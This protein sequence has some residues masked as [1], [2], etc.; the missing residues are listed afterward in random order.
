[1]RARVRAC[2]RVRVSCRVNPHPHPNPNPNPNP[3]PTRTRTLALTLTLTR[4]KPR[5][6]L[7][8]GMARRAL[9]AFSPLDNA[10]YLFTPSPARKFTALEGIRAL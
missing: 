10:R 6:V 3:N 1:M 5:V 9:L 2:C 4:G 8:L 7:R